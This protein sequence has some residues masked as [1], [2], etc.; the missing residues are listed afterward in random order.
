[1]KSLIPWKKRN[2]EMAGLR[3]DFDDAMDRFFSDPVFSIPK[4]FSEERRIQP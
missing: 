4:L 1:M 2:R 3:K